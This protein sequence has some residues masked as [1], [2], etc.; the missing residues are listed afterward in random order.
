MIVGE[1]ET[2]FSNAF[3]FLTMIFFLFFAVLYHVFRIFVQHSTSVFFSLLP[4]FLIFI[5]L[6]DIPAFSECLPA[7]IFGA[8]LRLAVMVVPNREKKLLYAVFLLDVITV[9]LFISHQR[10]TGG[11][12]AAKILCICLTVLTLSA[13]QTIVF[14]NNK[15]PFPIYYFLIISVITL[16]LPMREKPI[17][18]SFF[19]NIG[20]KIAYRVESVASNVSYRFTT[21]FGSYSSAGYSSLP[22]SGSKL[23]QKRKNQLI[24][25][26]YKAPYRTYTNEEDTLMMVRK[27]LYMPGG[28]GVDT[29]QFFKFLDFLYANGVDSSEATVFT[30]I[31]DINIE[32]DYIDTKDI[33]VP[34]NTFSA[35]EGDRNIE[36]GVSSTVH[37]RGYNIE[38]SYIDIDYGSPEFEEL[39]KNSQTECRE[40]TYSEAVAYASKLWLRNFENV[41]D[42]SEF[43]AAR[44]ASKKNE[45]ELKNYLDTKGADSKLQELAEEITS[46][47]LSDYD[48]CRKIEEYLKQYTYSLDTVGGYDP[49][50]DMSTAGGMSDIA[51]RFLFE[52]GKGYCVHYTSSMIM[53]LRLS[54]IPARATTGFRYGFPFEK[55]E[56]YRV[57][58]SYAHIWPEAYIKGVG[59]VPFEP[60]TGY[61]SQ[62]E[63]SWHRSKP[64]PKVEEPSES[65]PKES[66]NPYESSEK[67][68]VEP[69]EVEKVE[70][71]ENVEKEEKP[72]PSF[73]VAKVVIPVILFAG[74]SIILLLAGLYLIKRT[75]YKYGTPRQKLFYDVE[76]IKRVLIKRSGNRLKDRGI[77]SDFAEAAPKEMQEELGKVFSVFYRLIYGA[78][79]DADPTPEENALA[80]EVRDKL[81]HPKR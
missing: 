54:G 65:T 15:I 59:W 19:T 5:L 32:Y 2:L 74:I 45:S 3:P 23:R 8:T 16:I 53:L 18:W 55:A 40:L 9:Y 49:N 6:K 17:D 48:K 50:S 51:S 56:E 79:K 67:K 37:K 64:V 69:I 66:T 58:S 46:G 29:A 34:A 62:E 7:I 14:E 44:E 39:V 63:I 61:Y 22:A 27:T 43:E 41:I 76:Q 77:M 12:I 52:S 21:F 71:V 42:R 20:E 81:V 47:A 24:L 73:V 75:R 1:K 35:K 25:K 68:Q 80:L 33:I 26:I 36:E 78:S 10:F 70:E 60:T 30:E 72:E 4:S 28:R 57:S 38:A 11:S 13:V 31:S